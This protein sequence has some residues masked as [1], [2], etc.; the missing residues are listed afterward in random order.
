M[1]L[2]ST[3]TLLGRLFPNQNRS[4]ISTPYPRSMSFGIRPAPI[5]PAPPAIR[6]RIVRDPPYS[7]L[8]RYAILVDRQYFPTTAS[9]ATVSM[10]ELWRLCLKRRLHQEA[11]RCQF[12]DLYGISRTLPRSCRFPYIY[13]GPRTHL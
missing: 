7:N 8:R 4:T 1:S 13:I 6:M 3:P 11:N 10:I 12:Q 2:C 9:Q 5:Y